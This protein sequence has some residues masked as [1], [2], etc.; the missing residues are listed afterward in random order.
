VDR[1]TFGASSALSTDMSG[2]IAA[3][4]GEENQ[5]MAAA[6]ITKAFYR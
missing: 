1:E 3:A 2:L 6:P 4:P 5:P